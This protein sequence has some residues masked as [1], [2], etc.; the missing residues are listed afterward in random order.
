MASEIAA[1]S[2]SAPPAKRKRTSDEEEAAEETE[3]DRDNMQENGATIVNK[4]GKSKINVRSI[5]GADEDDDDEDDDDEDMRN[6]PPP[7]VIEV[8]KFKK[9]VND[10]LIES[11]RKLLLILQSENASSRFNSSNNVMHGQMGFG[12]VGMGRMDINQSF[13]SLLQ[14]YNQQLNQMMNYHQTEIQNWVSQNQQTM[15][16]WN[17][18]G[19]QSLFGGGGFGGHHQANFIVQQRMQSMNRTLSQDVYRDIEEAVDMRAAQDETSTKQKIDHILETSR[20]QHK[21]AREALRL[22]KKRH[23]AQLQL[24]LDQQERAVRELFEN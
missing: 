23:T 2:T 22:L 19:N 13:N 7:L 1:S 15:N 10:L 14:Y 12:A 8:V 16:S 11:Q 21:Q 5:I 17:N 18:M 24:L 9:T 3:E 4:N 6:P 20:L